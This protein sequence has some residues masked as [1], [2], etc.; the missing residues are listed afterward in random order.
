MAS[1]RRTSG[2]P[3]WAIMTLL[4]TLPLRNPFTV[5]C[6]ESEAAAASI[7]AFIASSSTSTVSLI[8]LSSR[9]VDV[10]RIGEFSLPVYIESLLEHDG[11]GLGEVPRQGVIAPPVA[12]R[13]SKNRVG[14]D[15]SRHAAPEYSDRHRELHGGHRA[16][17]RLRH[18]LSVVHAQNNGARQSAREVYLNHR[19]LRSLHL[20]AQYEGQRG[21]ESIDH[22]L[23]GDAVVVRGLQ[24]CV[25]NVLEVD[26][27]IQYPRLL[28]A[29]VGPLSLGAPANL[30]PRLVTEFSKARQRPG[31]NLTELIE[32]HQARLVSVHG[33]EGLVD[34]ANGIAHVVRPG[35]IEVRHRRALHH[36]LETEQVAEHV[37]H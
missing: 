35:A 18:R 23:F 9:A 17:C 20:L 10:A 28:K 33:H 1:D 31:G 24:Q 21:L 34:L 19:C 6:L 3:R 37:A 36:H 8:R 29:V 12:R 22:Y 2:P 32:H 16:T 14:V 4:G 7:A 27:A 30:V 25:T 15:A 5:I 26:P 13:R 11:E